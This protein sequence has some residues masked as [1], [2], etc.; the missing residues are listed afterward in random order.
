MDEGVEKEGWRT[1]IVGGERGGGDLYFA[2]DVTNPDEPIL[3][4]GVFGGQ[5]PDPVHRP[6]P[7]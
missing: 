4:L 7:V 3:L 1:I 2:F 6:Q 5:G